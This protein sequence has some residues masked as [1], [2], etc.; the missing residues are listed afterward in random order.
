MDLSKYRE[1]RDCL[2]VAVSSARDLE[3][4]HWLLGA[5][6]V[7]SG[8]TLMYLHQFE[9]AE[10]AMLEGHEILLLNFDDD[11]LR[12]RASGWNLSTLYRS[13]ELADPH[14]SHGEEAGFWEAEY[15]K[16]G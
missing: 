4:E 7:T 5:T 1:A 6:L 10:E 2:A 13:W 3:D 8:L 16:N 15:P 12:V 11:H 9:D 14:G